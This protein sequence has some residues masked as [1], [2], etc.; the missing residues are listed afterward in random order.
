MRQ[1]YRIDRDDPK[2]AAKAERAIAALAGKQCGVVSARQLHVA[3]FDGSAIHRRVHAGRLHRVHRGVYLVGHAV[4]ADGASEMAAVLS[5]GE[6]SAVSHRSAGR[7]WRFSANESWRT[8]VEV[9]VP[10]RDPGVKPGIRVYR[11]RELDRRDVRRVRGIPV[12]SPAR[13]LLDLAGLLPLETVESAFAEARVRRLVRDKDVAEQ[14]KRARGRRGAAALRRLVALERGP[15]L[16]RSAAER[17]LLKLV[18]EAALPPPELNARLGRFEVDFLW[19]GP[20]V[21]VEVDG[22][23]YHSSARAFERD[24]ERDAM[25]VAGGYSVIRVTWRQLSASPE[26]VI[27]RIES[28][29]AVR[30]TDRSQDIDPMCSRP[31]SSV[32]IF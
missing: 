12:T 22:R 30:C 3:G 32:A 29:L 17:K 26:A 28:A 23:A 18:R 8:P 27:A 10:G 14:L 25:L 7:L 11:V 20:R 13:T 9:T 5:S 24:R 2:D 15:A 19:R 6:G 21:V 1:Q 16:T 4:A 31:P